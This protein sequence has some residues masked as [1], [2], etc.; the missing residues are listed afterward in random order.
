MWLTYLI[1][2]FWSNRNWR[3]WV[4]MWKGRRRGPVGREIRNINNNA[5]MG[6]EEV[7]GDDVDQNELC[8]VCLAKRRKSIFVHCGHR[9]CC[10]QCAAIIKNGPSPRCPIC[11]EDV[12]AVYRVFDA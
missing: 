12:E 3:R 5:D 1:F 2:Y 4:N 8:I 7:V 6:D 11:R 10:C 9:V